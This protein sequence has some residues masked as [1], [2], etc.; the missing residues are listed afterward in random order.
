[1]AFAVSTIILAL[2]PSFFL[3]ESFYADEMRLTT[4]L[5]GFAGSIGVGRITGFAALLIVCFFVVIKRNWGYK[6]LLSPL[7]AVFIFLML[8]S[9]T[10]GALIAFVVSLSILFT[11]VLKIKKIF[12][13]KRIFILFLVFLFSLGIIYAL[14]SNIPDEL[15]DRYL[16]LSSGGTFTNNYRMI[17]IKESIQMFKKSPIIGCG[18]GSFYNLV[19]TYPHN[20]F[21]EIAG[22]LG[23]AGLSIFIYFIISTFL[24]AFKSISIS[25]NSNSDLKFAITAATI[26]FVFYLTEAQFSFNLDLNGIIWFFAGFIWAA[27]ACIISKDY[28]YRKEERFYVE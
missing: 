24:R 13:F 12:L 20:I 6:L 21:L 18:T 5:M 9:G 26:G 19:G 23:L 16:T 14:W 2:I 3:G 1:M 22:Y 8:R 27:H 4:R 11:I 10:R 7:L 17:L 28:T 15:R 25:T